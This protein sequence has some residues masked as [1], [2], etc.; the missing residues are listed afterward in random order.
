MKDSSFSSNSGGRRILAAKHVPDL[1]NTA[2]CR[3]EMTLHGGDG[4]DEQEGRNASCSF[5]TV[6][7][8][9]EMFER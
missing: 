5:L 6:V 9:G 1:E 3:L 4:R 2:G 8:I 7:P